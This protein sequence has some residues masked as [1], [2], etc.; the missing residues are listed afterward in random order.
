MTVRIFLSRWD[1]LIGLTFLVGVGLYLTTGALIENQM[2][3]RWR[4][5]SLAGGGTL[6]LHPDHT[7]T[8]AIRLGSQIRAKG[9]GRW[10]F[11]GIS[12]TIRLTSRDG[13]NCLA[14]YDWQ[15]KA[16][17]VRFGGSDLALP[18]VRDD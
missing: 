6:E 8:L 2:I 4:S 11:T 13:L 15:T 3:G 18:F 16:L 12:Q 14:E 10:E 9:E 5:A 17:T 1:V 7:C